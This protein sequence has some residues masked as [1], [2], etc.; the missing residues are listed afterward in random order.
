MKSLIKSVSFVLILVLGILA[1]CQNP[2]QSERDSEKTYQPRTQA[3]KAL[4]S[5]TN[6]KIDYSGKA[7]KIASNY[8]DMGQTAARSAG[9]VIDPQEVFE[10][11]TGK[12]T[13]TV[14][15][16]NGGTET[17]TVEQEMEELIGKMKKDMA[18]AAP[19]VS[20]LLTHPSIDPGPEP[21]TVQVGDQVIDGRSAG[22]AVAIEALKAQLR[23]EGIEDIQKDLSEFAAEGISEGRGFYLNNT[24]RWPWGRVNYWFDPHG[25][26]SG[27]KRDVYRAAAEWTRKTNVNLVEV[28][29]FFERVSASLS[30]GGY[31][32][33]YERHA[34]YRSNSHFGANN[35]VFS[36]MNLANDE[37]MPTIRHEI[38]HAIG[39]QHEHQR[40][41]RDL[42]LSG[43]F[44][45]DSNQAIINRTFNFFHIYFRLTRIRF[46]FFDFYIWL[47]V[48]EFKAGTHNRTT[49]YD[50]FSIMHYPT[51]FPKD[52]DPRAW[53]AKRRQVAYIFNDDQGRVVRYEINPGDM[54][55]GYYTAGFITLL[56]IQAVNLMYDGH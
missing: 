8:V 18:A 22:G 55:N 45:S 21:H 23:G 30:G 52:D 20:E 41:D 50:Y 2:S 53:K 13:R 1:G 24:T 11:L 40:P 47:P 38:G 34:G 35:G 36:Q 42:Y 12:E 54:V 9:G 19:D 17:V 28:D 31:V 51:Q 6:L 15:G 49:A 4:Q 14:P 33:I 27:L 29:G 25:V 26:S 10:S 48:I 32:T 44:A 16:R 3:G 5:F 56:D 7:M 37:D 43:A 46:L 39:L